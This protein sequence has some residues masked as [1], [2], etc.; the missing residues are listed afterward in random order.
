MGL[1][2]GLVAGTAARQEQVQD[3]RHAHLSSLQT[4]GSVLFNP[5]QYVIIQN[6]VKG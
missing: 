4:D 3:D 5:V 2:S 1:A 6:G